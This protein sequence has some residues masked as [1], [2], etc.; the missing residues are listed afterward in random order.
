MNESTLLSFYLP[1]SLP[2]F[3]PR[4]NDKTMM[5]KLQRT[6]DNTNF[7]DGRNLSNINW[8]TLRSLL[9]LFICRYPLPFSMLLLG[10][11]VQITT[12]KSRLQKKLNCLF[13]TSISKVTMHFSFGNFLT[14]RR[15]YTI[16]TYSNGLKCMYLIQPNKVA[17]FR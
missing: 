16:Q 17:T 13:S 12:T 6:K 3:F 11:K 1:D 2:N 8:K 9:K 7:L 14:N 10:I 5:D 4:A 15:F